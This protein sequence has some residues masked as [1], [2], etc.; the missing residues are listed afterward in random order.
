MVAIDPSLPGAA[1]LPPF[2]GDDN[3]DPTRLGGDVML[4][5]H[6]SDPTVLTAVLADLTAMLPGARP[7]WEQLIFRGNGEGTKARNPL[8]FMD[9]IVVPRGDAELEKSVWIGSG[10]L[11]GATVCVIRRLRIDTARFRAQTVEAREAIIGRR[12]GDGAPLSGGGPDDQVNLTAKTPEGE[13]L[14]PARSHSRGAHPSF[15]GSGLMFRRSYSFENEAEA[16]LVFISFQSEL[17]TFTVTQQRLDEVDDLMKYVTPTA[18]GTF[19]M[20]PG[21]STRAPLGS[22]LFA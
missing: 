15:T 9:G 17:R 12:L 19:L 11:T 1:E 20:L 10:A 13:Y 4:S 16:G 7:R 3:I 21:F 6:S 5:A 22:S 8:G 18:S 14:V 2:A